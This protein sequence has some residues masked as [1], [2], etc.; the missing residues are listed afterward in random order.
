MSEPRKRDHDADKIQSALCEIVS[1][2]SALNMEPDPLKVPI[3]KGFYLSELD[4]W[5]AH[6]MEHLHAV[7]EYLSEIY[8]ERARDR[9]KI[10]RLE[11]R[12]MGG[13]KKDDGS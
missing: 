1:A 2:M 4:G 6:C 5:A 9:D 11:L 12:N 3:G 8:Q 10:F 13:T 7:F